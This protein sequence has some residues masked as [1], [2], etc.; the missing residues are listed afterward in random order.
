MAPECIL[1]NIRNSYF[2]FDRVTEFRKHCSHNYY[3]ANIF[4]FKVYY[5]NTRKR[6][7]I[8]SKLTIKTPE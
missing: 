1:E 5:R 2:Y 8:W 7:E 6:C 3:P 4:L